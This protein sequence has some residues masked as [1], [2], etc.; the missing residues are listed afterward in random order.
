MSSFTR[1]AVVDCSTKRAAAIA[2]G[3]RGVPAE[4]LTG[5]KCTP[6]DIV[7]ADVAAR[8][9]VSSPHELLQTFIEGNN[10][11]LNGDLLTVDSTDYPI[12]SI[13]DWTHWRDGQ[14]KHLILEAIK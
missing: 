7:D 3:K 10:D 1:W 9:G 11:I 13:A 4:N 14:W 5:L 6:L 8:S 12:K 2:G